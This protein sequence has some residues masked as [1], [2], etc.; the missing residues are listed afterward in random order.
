MLLNR[1]RLTFLFNKYLR[2]NAS[3]EE[4]EEFFSYIRE[5][6]QDEVLK[7]E[8]IRIFLQ[9]RSPKGAEE[10]DWN[11][12]FLKAIGESAADS[13]TPKVI[14][15]QFKTWKKVAAA[16]LILILGGTGSYLYLNKE[17]S[18]GVAKAQEEV[19]DISPGGN[20]AILTLSNNTT[21]LLDSAD[22]GRLASQGG[23]NIVKISSGRLAYKA[24]L[25]T[26]GQAGQLQEMQY[27]TLTTPRAGQYQL[28][29]SDGTKV[30]LNSASSI[31]YPTAFIGKKRKVEITGEVYFEV[32]HDKA[33]PFEVQAGS[34]MIEDLGTRFNVN[35]YADEP[36]IKT[37]LLEGSIK[38]GSAVLKPGEQA[39][40]K[41][42]GKIDVIENRNPDDAIAW[43]KGLFAF[44][45]ASLQTVMRELSRWYD[46]DVVYEAGAGNMQRFSGRI[47]RNLT[48]SQILNGLKQ[49]RAHFKIE[50]DQKIVIIR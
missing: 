37:T 26:A 47:D 38:I 44:N 8:I 15:S 7:E 25:G 29:L 13:D 42:D 24:D 46:I 2:D 20:R 34:Q 49:T 9:E 27:N 40:I 21:V 10:V 31:H 23:V 28:T 4:L 5:A 3:P 11:T 33:R 17:H 19:N 43:T 41:K 22:N 12:M 35:A 16:I 1:D 30:W 18:E 50:A 45:E 48:L 36:T 14:V 32:K 39:I 6:E